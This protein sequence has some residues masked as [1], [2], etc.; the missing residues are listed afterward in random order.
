MIYYKVPDKMDNFY[1]RNS[2]Y[3]LVK[4]ELLTLKEAQR[5][6]APIDNLELVEIS[7]RKTYRFF[8]CRFE[9]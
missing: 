5:M 8:G 9:M 1:I 7:S 2:G 3:T 4:N 6:K